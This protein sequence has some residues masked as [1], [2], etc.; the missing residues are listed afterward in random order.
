VA[1]PFP[2]TGGH[3]VLQIAS[4]EAPKEEDFATQQPAIEQRLLQAKRQ[5]AFAVFEDN[6]RSRLEAEGDLVIYHDVLSRMAAGAPGEHPPYPH[7][8]PP[9]F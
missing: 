5:Q 1:G 9:G 3:V 4:R 6:L 8:H 7:S 2:T